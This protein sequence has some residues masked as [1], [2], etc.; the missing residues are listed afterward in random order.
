[1]YTVYKTIFDY[2]IS[3]YKILGLTKKWLD[4]K[5]KNGV[6]IFSFGISR[7]VRRSQLFCRI[8]IAIL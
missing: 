5:A 1:M 7:M 8:D 4:T 2:C 3:S 6:A